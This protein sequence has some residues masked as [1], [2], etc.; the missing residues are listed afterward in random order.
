MFLTFMS[1]VD[2]QIIPKLSMASKKAIATKVMAVHN[3]HEVMLGI[4]GMADMVCKDRK[5][6]RTITSQ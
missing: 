3:E 4:S 2:L 6:D 5:K 1:C